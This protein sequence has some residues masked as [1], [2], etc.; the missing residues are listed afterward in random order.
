MKGEAAEKLITLAIPVD[1]MESVAT[2][3]KSRLDFIQEIEQAAKLF[4]KREETLDAF[5]K[6]H[7][8]L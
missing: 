1:K 2:S 4:D 6:E 7:N 8:R 3:I 5:L